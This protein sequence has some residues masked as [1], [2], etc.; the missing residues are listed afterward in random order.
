LQIAALALAGGRD[1][2]AAEASGF[3][4][5]ALGLVEA[6]RGFSGPRPLPFIPSE[7]LARHG[8]TAQDYRERRATPEIAA[9]LREL[10]T[11]ARR[12]LS[13]AE[14][15]RARLPRALAPAYTGLA[16]AP[17]WLDA[18]ERRPADVAAV[19]AWRRQ[20]ALWRWMRRA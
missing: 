9:C 2:G 7:T 15:A 12:R 1:P 6:L 8:A 10:A 14:A 5:V 11:L 18:L 4:G 20:W 13:E 17:L 19:P 3:A 16:T